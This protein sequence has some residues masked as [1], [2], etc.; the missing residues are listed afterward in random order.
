MGNFIEKICF[1]KEYI[2]NWKVIGAIS[3]SSKKLA[4]K[5]VENIDFQTAKN[6]VE[7]GPGTG[8]FTEE[9]VN[10]KRKGTKLFVIEYNLKFYNILKEKYGHIEDVYIINDSAE[11]IDIHLNKYEVY[12]I[13]YI[14]SG[15]PFASLEKATSINILKKSNEL[16]K[17][18]GKFIT[19]QYTLLKKD[20]INKFFFNI[21]TS[22]VMKN[23]PPAYV[24]SCDKLS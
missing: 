22:R 8:V 6:I 21:E 18:N 24:L 5:M 19:F 2:L 7:Y 4:Y 1:I 13:D 20:F 16:L 9:L 11:K 12:K 15:L 17:E 10:R 23:L 14:V 3:P